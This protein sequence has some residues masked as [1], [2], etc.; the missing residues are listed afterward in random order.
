MNHSHSHGK[1]FLV[2]IPA[3]FILALAFFIRIV[4]YEPLIPK[5]IANPEEASLEIPILPGDP[6][7]G[8]K[9]SGITIIAFEDFSCE[10]CK[11]Q[12]EFLKEIQD[13]HP[14]RVKVIWKGL[15]VNTFPVNS[16][17]AHQ[18]AYCANAQKKF[19]EFSSYAFVNGSN[20]TEDTLQTI[21]TEIDL[22]ESTL[23]SCLSNPA[24]DEHIDTTES[25]ARSL[26]IQA[27]PTFFLNKKQIQNPNSINEWETLLGL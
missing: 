6:I 18:Y 9:K 3:I 22:K 11:V 7:I 5:E 13:K 17:L 23:E 20:L 21:A 25:L 10:N 19:D 12:S 26:S 2:F 14:K 27:V 8:D 1:L 15:P 16:R 4:Q 24:V